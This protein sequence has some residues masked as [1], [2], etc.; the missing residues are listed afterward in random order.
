MKKVAISCITALLT[1]AAAALA[2]ES[3]SHSVY[4]ITSYNFGTLEHL[5]G[6]SLS[7]A[8]AAGFPLLITG[9][10]SDVL[11]DLNTDDELLLASGKNSATDGFAISAQYSPSKKF[12][13]QGAF[14]FTD[15]DWDP[16]QENR[17]A[18]W[19][20]NLGIVYNLFDKLSYGVHFGYMDT[21][22][23]YSR[24]STYSDVESVIMISNQLTLSF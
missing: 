20:A 18:S 19:E 15:S 9:Y 8:S 4:R 14:G 5:E 22:D 21:G 24:R 2:D 6:E 13:V 11:S 23:I 1:N 17:A 16:G 3:S 10:Q 12:A 7:M